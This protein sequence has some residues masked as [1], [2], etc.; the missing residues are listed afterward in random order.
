MNEEIIKKVITWRRYLHE[1]PELSFHEEKTTEYIYGIVSS[2]EGVEISR[3]ARTG[4]LA[5]LR[6]NGPGPVIALRGD[7]DALPITEENSVDYISKNPGVMHACGH[8]SHTAMLLGTLLSLHSTRESWNGEIR[9]FF[10]HGEE[11]SPGGAVDFVKAGAL[12][13]VS[14]ILGTHVAPDVESGKVGI[15]YGPAMAE[16]DEFKV[17]IT[18]KGGHGAIPQETIDPIMIGVQIAQNFQTIISRNVGPMENAVLSITQFHGGTTHNVIPGKAEL[19]GTVRTFNVETRDLIKSRMEQ[20]IEG[21]CRCNNARGSFEFIEG[22]PCVIND[23]EVTALLEETAKAV[24]GD[25]NVIPRA[26]FMGGEDFGEY[27]KYI[28]G[29]FYFLGIKGGDEGKGNPLHHPQFNLDE[30]ALGAGV[31]VMVNGALALLKKYEDK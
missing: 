3:P 19:C 8:D 6:G 30:A 22:Y 17:V 11:L 9:F 2:L 5:V 25:E 24:L 4:L 20:I 27:Q 15:T 21:V 10:Q 28:P 26:P 12:E 16:P 7:M 29:C 1:N 14:A 13:G 31:K 23:R 18:G